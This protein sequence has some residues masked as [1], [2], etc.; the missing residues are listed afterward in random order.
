MSSVIQ[1]DLIKHSFG[2]HSMEATFRFNCG[3]KGCLHQ[4]RS[5]ATFSSFKS[6]ASR[7]HPNWHKDINNCDQDQPTSM[8]TS[9]Q[10]SIPF[11]SPNKDE[12]DI[13]N[14]SESTIGPI[15]V[16]D[17]IELESA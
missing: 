2:A 17:N 5:G 12:S 13:D 6:H 15:D 8:E 4:F 9:H 3:I 16:P 11:I 14:E 10:S 1:P 7:K